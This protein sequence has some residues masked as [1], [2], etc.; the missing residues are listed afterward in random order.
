VDAVRPVV[1]SAHQ[2]QHTDRPLPCPGVRRLQALALTS[3]HGAVVEVEVQETHAPGF[4]IANVLPGPAG[5]SEIAV[6]RGFRNRRQCCRKD[7]RRRQLERVAGFLAAQV[8]DPYCAI[9]RCAQDRRLAPGDHLARRAGAW[10]AWILFRPGV[11]QAAGLAEQAIGDA[12]KTIGGVDP[13]QHARRFIALPVDGTIDL[14]HQRPLSA[15]NGR[16]G[17]V[18][19]RRHEATGQEALDGFQ[20]RTHRG[21]GHLVAIEA[22]LPGHSHRKGFGCPDRAGIHLGGRLQDRHPPVPLAS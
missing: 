15:W 22:R 4:F 3:A 18:D 21:F 20:Q 16:V 2:H 10:R 12:G 14:L 11:E 7:L 1:A 8:T 6:E 5:R 13:G 17:I 9:D 19:R